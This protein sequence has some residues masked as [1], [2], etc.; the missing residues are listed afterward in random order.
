MPNRQESSDSLQPGRLAPQI[1]EQALQLRPGLFQMPSMRELFLQEQQMHLEW[2]QREPKVLDSVEFYKDAQGFYTGDKNVW[3]ESVRADVVDRVLVKGRRKGEEPVIFLLGVGGPGSGKSTILGDMVE[4]IVA[5]TGAE[6]QHSILETKNINARRQKLVTR[7][8]DWGGNFPILDGKH[9]ELHGK[10]V[11][12]RVPEWVDYHDNESLSLLQRRDLGIGNIDLGDWKRAELE[13]ASQIWR[14]TLEELAGRYY[15]KKLKYPGLY[16]PRKVADIVRMDHPGY[17][18]EGPEGF[19]R[20]TDLLRDFINHRGSFEE[21]NY[22]VIP[23]GVVALPHVLM[24]NQSMRPEDRNHAGLVDPLNRDTIIARD[25]EERRL[26]EELYIREAASRSEIETFNS[27]KRIGHY[28][29]EHQMGR[30]DNP[31]SLLKQIYGVHSNIGARQETEMRDLL[32]H[33]FSG[34]LGVKDTSNIP[35]IVN[36]K[37]EA[38][39]RYSSV[40]LDRPANDLNAVGLYS[41]RM[42]RLTSFGS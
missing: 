4:Q 21:L 7:T 14:V 22:I 16:D 41:E 26:V 24:H 5:G 19:D 23:F 42:P 39:L 3:L 29:Q 37:V 34:V 28:Q 20:A 31:I 9:I 6:D 25:E 12:A 8:V 11:P 10:W 15:Y 40:C 17:T 30:R 38:G 13:A 27:D 33:T 2:R 1:I 35:I 18:G 36:C 32:P